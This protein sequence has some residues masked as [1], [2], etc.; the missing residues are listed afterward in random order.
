M[1]CVCVWEICHCVRY[2]I[3]WD[4]SLCEICHCVSQLKNKLYRCY[5]TSVCGN[6]EFTVETLGTRQQLRLIDARSCPRFSECRFECRA[7]FW[8]SSG[9]H[10]LNRYGH[11]RCDRQNLKKNI[12]KISDQS[13]LKKFRQPQK[14]KQVNYIKEKKRLVWS[15]NCVHIMLRLAIDWFLRHLNNKTSW[16]FT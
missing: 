2:V 6:S 3:V 1:I 16:T 10:G 8:F 13:S 11:I 12:L 4:M 14:W 15:R 5:L 9:V 7:V